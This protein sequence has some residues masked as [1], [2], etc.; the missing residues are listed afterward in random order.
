MGIG[1]KTI[2]KEISMFSIHVGLKSI[3]YLLNHEKKIVDSKKKIFSK[4]NDYSNH[5]IDIK[6][7]IR[8]IEK[9]DILINNVKLIYY[10]SPLSLIPNSV[11][12]NK[13]LSNYLKSR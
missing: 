7:T 9:N 12:D 6:K 13:Y 4:N 3:Y 5:F 2:Q 1:Q 8:S 11:F 10:D